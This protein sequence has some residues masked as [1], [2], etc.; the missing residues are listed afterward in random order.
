MLYRT[1]DSGLLELMFKDIKG[2]KTTK[3]L[4]LDTFV[5]YLCLTKQIVWFYN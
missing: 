1:S 4:K 3:G 2:Y 5:L